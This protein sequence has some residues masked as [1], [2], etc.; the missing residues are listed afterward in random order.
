VC[1]FFIPF[2]SK[3]KKSGHSGV[4]T[5]RTYCDSTVNGDFCTNQ[6][7]DWSSFAEQLTLVAVVEMLFFSFSLFHDVCCQQFWSMMIAIH[8]ER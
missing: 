7:R 4:E 6:K 1:V 5:S 2:E 8:D 3:Q